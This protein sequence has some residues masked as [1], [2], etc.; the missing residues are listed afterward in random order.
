MAD[1]PVNM[2][3]DFPAIFLLPTHLEK[4]RR[5][6]LEE[7]I[8]S[9]T[10]DIREAEVVIGNISKRERALFE[11]RHRK[12]QTDPLEAA[13]SAE[14]QLITPRKRKRTSVESESGYTVYTEDVK[15]DGSGT[16]QRF[17]A[18]SAPKRTGNTN[19]IKVVKLS[20]LTESLAQ[21]KL[22]PLHSYIIYEG[23]KRDAPETPAAAKGNGILLRA[24]AD[25]TSQAQGGSLLK[26]RRGRSPHASH[27]TVPSLIRQTTSGHDSALNL[28]PV[29]SFLTTTY[30]CQR[31]TPA[32]PPNATFIDELK[33]IR[34]TRK[35]SGDQIGVRAYSTSI[36]T[37]SAYPYAIASTQGEQTFHAITAT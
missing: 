17:E 35:L 14:S 22:L 10:Y 19:T 29:P 11:L 37:I 33:K 23:L 30:A 24:T 31:A 21:N 1:C 3:L 36:A 18:S 34:T 12:V 7:K 25:A 26:T 9:L 2:G 28:P 8:P 16:L 13:E 5:H 15:Q 27:R 32:N 4:D 20:W 6:E